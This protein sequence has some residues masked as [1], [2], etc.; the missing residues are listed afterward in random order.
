MTLT[1]LS[2]ITSTACPL[3][4]SLEAAMDAKVASPSQYCRRRQ[5]GR[6]EKHELAGVGRF[7]RTKGKGSLIFHLRQPRQMGRGSTSRVKLPPNGMRFL[8]LSYWGMVC[9]LVLATVPKSSHIWSSTWTAPRLHVFA[10]QDGRS[11][12]LSAK[13]EMRVA[14]SSFQPHLASWINVTCKGT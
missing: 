6:E 7:W 12:C 13:R 1:S 3:L 10:R 9:E 11:I 4:N 2:E 5:K 8:V 14:A